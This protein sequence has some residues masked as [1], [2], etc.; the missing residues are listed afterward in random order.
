MLS[1]SKVVHDQ[2]PMLSNRLVRSHSVLSKHLKDPGA[3]SAGPASAR[4]K[5]AV[6]IAR[7]FERPLA[8]SERGCGLRCLSASV[9]TP[10]GIV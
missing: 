3:A 9:Q 4:S 8:D 5:A 2:G 10:M 1:T 7:S 6:A